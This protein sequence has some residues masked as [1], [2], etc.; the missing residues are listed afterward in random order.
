M[1]IWCFDLAEV[2]DGN[3]CDDDDDDDDNTPVVVLIQFMWCVTMARVTM[4]IQKYQKRRANIQ[5]T[6][7]NCQLT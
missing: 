4:I 7:Q 2:N 1:E 6:L 5:P 3:N